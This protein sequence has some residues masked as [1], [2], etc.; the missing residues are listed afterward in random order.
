MT[1][2]SQTR[3]VARLERY[4]QSHSAVIDDYVWAD[5]DKRFFETMFA[6]ALAGDRNW[7][8]DDER[9][10]HALLLGGRPEDEQ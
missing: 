8:R 10:Y 5:D 3:R 7:G 9:R 4:K 1:S 6:R 2:P